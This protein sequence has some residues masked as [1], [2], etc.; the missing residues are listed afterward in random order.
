MS[1]VIKSNFIYVTSNEKKVIDNDNKD[2][3]R[4]NV[5]PGAGNAGK[6][7]FANIDYS[8]DAY[9]VEAVLKLEAMKEEARKEEVRKSI[10]AETEKS[11][12]DILEQAKEKAKQII[13]DAMIE[14]EALKKDNFEEAKNEGYAQ[15]YDLAQ[16]DVEELRQALA[17]QM[18]A[19][20]EEYENKLCQLE[21]DMIDIITQILENLTGIEID[22]KDVILHVI[23]RTFSGIEHSA[24]YLIRVSPQ[25]YQIVNDNVSNLYECVREGANIEVVSD[26]K[27]D[28]NQC[29][30]ETD[31]NVIDCSLDEQIR[32]VCKEL[33][34][35]SLL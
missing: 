10:L 27:L 34:V 30:I 11:A 24:E 21:T 6:D 4:E 28:K 25:D 17:I 5:I 23:H 29:L 14:A 13:D 1:N 15:G 18:Q 20:N 12:N 26:D 31:S 32:N 2:N 9:K 7:G 33:K 8:N 19:N 35:L 16:R 22:D 3:K